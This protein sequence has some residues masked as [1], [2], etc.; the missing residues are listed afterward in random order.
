MKQVL[1]MV[2]LCLIAAC[3]GEEKKKEQIATRQKLDTPMGAWFMYARGARPGY[4][5]KMIW[6][7]KL[8]F[9]YSATV[10]IH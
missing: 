10:R 1:G 5:E 3:A 8:P 9:S 7:E 4:V 2:L 6:I